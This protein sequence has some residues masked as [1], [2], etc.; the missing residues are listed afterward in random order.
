MGHLTRIAN[1][2][3]ANLE[4]GPNTDL[5]QSLLNGKIFFIRLCC[6]VMDEIFAYICTGW[7]TNPE[8]P[9]KRWIFFAPGKIPWKTLKIEPTPEKCSESDL[10]HINIQRCNILCS[11]TAVEENEC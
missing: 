9:E 8:D 11:R 1:S 6:S 5:L 7:P 4:K 3:A 2:L 10:P